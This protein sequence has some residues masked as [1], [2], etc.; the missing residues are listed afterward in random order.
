VVTQ[1]KSQHTSSPYSEI[2]PEMTE[3][4]A[5]HQI[6]GQGGVEREKVAGRSKDEK[7]FR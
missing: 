4:Q 5:T 1:Q 3:Q 7:S 2:E 6:N